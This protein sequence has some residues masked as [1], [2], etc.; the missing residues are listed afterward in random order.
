MADKKPRPLTALKKLARERDTPETIAALA[1][2][3][4]TAS[5]RAL[6][7]VV[8]SILDRSLEDTLLEWM[9]ELSTE[10]QNTLF[11]SRGVL[12][13]FSAKID[14]AYAF[15]IFGPQTRADLH[16]IREVRNLF[17]H[18][19]LPLSFSD[20]AIARSIYA[21]N[22]RKQPGQGAFVAPRA[23]FVRAFEHLD[24]SL[25]VL[26]VPGMERFAAEKGQLL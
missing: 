17:A 14:L 18:A 1:K 5:D 4:Q 8:A 15:R 25:C 19:R 23:A 26:A 12:A 9:R 10:D 22:L 20:E 24:A 2:E 6:A 21:L 3:L 11:A 7:V 13:T 16:T